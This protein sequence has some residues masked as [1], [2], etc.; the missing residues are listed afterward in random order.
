M[1]RLGETSRAVTSPSPA[2][3]AHPE[4]ARRAG[5][6]AFPRLSCRSTG[7]QHQSQEVRHVRHDLR[8]QG[9][10]DVPG[11]QRSEPRVIDGVPWRRHADLMLLC[12]LGSDSSGEPLCLIRSSA[13]SGA[14]LLK[15]QYFK[16]ETSGSRMLTANW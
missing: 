8:Q 9:H 3:V 7:R 11:V 14:E 13:E 5:G 16:V 15:V 1:K 6:P 10:H 2:A 12:P 4:E